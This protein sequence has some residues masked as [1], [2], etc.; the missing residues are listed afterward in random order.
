MANEATNG[1]KNLPNPYSTENRAAYKMGSIES[2]LHDT[3]GFRTG[4]DKY[5]EEMDNAASAWDAQQAN[6]AYEEEYNSAQ[7]QTARMQA[8]GLN[9]D[10]DPSKIA[11]GEATEFTEPEAAPESPMGQD[12]ETLEKAGEGAA[13]LAMF[14]LDMFNGGIAIKTALQGLKN[15]KVEGENTEI[16]GSKELFEAVQKAHE[17]YGNLDKNGNG[18]TYASGRYVGKAMGYSNRRL[19]EFARMYDDIYSSVPVIMKNRENLNTLAKTNWTAENLDLILGTEKLGL[20][21]AAS[22]ALVEATRN[23][24]IAEVLENYPEFTKEQLLAGNIEAIARAAAAGDEAKITHYTAR[25]EKAVQE[26]RTINAESDKKLA[27]ED[28]KIIE[29]FYNERKTTWLDAAIP[30]Y[31]AIRKMSVRRMYE[32]A[33]RRRMGKNAD[34]QDNKVKTPKIKGKL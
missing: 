20:E 25:A 13:G 17:I 12:L 10:L 23:K 33:T 26:V 24:Q 29:N 19:D 4:V 5:N 16:K 3:L 1:R 7:A 8:A 22:K 2:F 18:L 34:V 27:E 28:N 11:P 14:V 32:R 30:A 15:M 6:N 21:A 31:G 9:P